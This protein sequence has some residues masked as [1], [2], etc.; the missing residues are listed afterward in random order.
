MDVDK[1]VWNFYKKTRLFLKKNKSNILINSIDV[2]NFIKFHEDYLLKKKELLKK[3]HFEL[4]FFIFK[5]NVNS[6]FIW[7]LKY[8]KYLAIKKKIIPHDTEILFFSFLF[9]AQKSSYK[10]SQDPVFNK[11]YTR[12]KKKKTITFVLFDF[13]SNFKIKENQRIIVL[14]KILSLQDEIKILFYQFQVSVFLLKTLINKKIDFIFFLQLLTSIFSFETKNNLRFLL[15][16]KKIFLNCNPKYFVAT[17]EGY[18][19]EKIAFYL[20]KK[21]NPKCKIIGYQNTFMPKNIFWFEDIDKLYSPHFIFTSGDFNKKKIIKKNKFFKKR[22]FVIGTNRYSNV[23]KSKIDKNNCLIL[24]E[25]TNY[26]MRLLFLFA[27]QLA[28]LNQSINFIIRTHPLINLN[29]FLN[30]NL[31]NYN[32]NLKNI[33]ISKKSFFYDIKRSNIAIYRG[34]TSIIPAIQNNI[35]PVYYNYKESIYNID[36][37]YDTKIKTFYIKNEKDFFEVLNNANS[38][39]KKYFHNN[40][41]EA[42]KFFSPINYRKFYNLVSKF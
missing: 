13:T 21:I 24:P 11:I 9:E 40:R 25:A 8:F 22:V 33:I 37:I 23:K 3:K 19:W 2:L 18:I 38:L 35:L 31:R 39:K 28:E 10:Q 16:F 32:F 6:F 17:F 4:F 36:P 29:S 26:E 1:K 5:N 42:K 34:S 7:I 27:L 12:L 14:K 20:S 30:N 15:Q 41:L